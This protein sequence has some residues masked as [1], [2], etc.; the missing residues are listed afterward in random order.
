VST[1]H[2]A[3]KVPFGDPRDDEHRE[4]KRVVAMRIECFSG[5]F[6]VV[7]HLGTCRSKLTIKSG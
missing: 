7:K 2:I 6:G 4:R 3:P 1:L 5:A